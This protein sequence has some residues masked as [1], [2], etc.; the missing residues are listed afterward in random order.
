MMHLLNIFI[1]VLASLLFGNWFNNDQQIKTSLSSH[2]GLVIPVL[3]L[4]FST[5]FVIRSVLEEDILFM[6][7]PI[8]ICAIGLAGTVIGIKGMNE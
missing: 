3:M 6:K 8:F 2:T 4:L 7:V 1:F 5:L